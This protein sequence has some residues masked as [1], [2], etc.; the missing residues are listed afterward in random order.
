MSLV[1]DF[2]LYIKRKCAAYLMSVVLFLF[3]AWTMYGQYILPNALRPQD[4]MVAILEQRCRGMCVSSY[5]HCFFWQPRWSRLCVIIPTKTPGWMFCIDRPT[6]GMTALY[7][8]SLSLEMLKLIGTTI[9]MGDVEVPWLHLKWRT[10]AILLTKSL[11]HKM[12][13]L[14]QGPIFFTHWTWC[15]WTASFFSKNTEKTI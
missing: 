6:F 7:R 14:V 11:A 5:E 13:T 8:K 3:R 15:A 1:F 10:T 4:N 2:E 12:Y 9:Y